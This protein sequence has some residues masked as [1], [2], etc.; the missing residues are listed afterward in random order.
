MQRVWWAT[1]SFSSIF[2]KRDALYKHA[3]S[4]HLDQVINVDW[5][6]GVHGAWCLELVRALGLACTDSGG[7][8]LRLAVERRPKIVVFL[9]LPRKNS[10]KSYMPLE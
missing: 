5:V 8:A 1:P 7:V 2:G 6:C 9:S 10:A 3:F 4:E